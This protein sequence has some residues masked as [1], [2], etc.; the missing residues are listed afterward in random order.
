[1]I[2]DP[3][4]DI[5]RGKAV[6]I[7]P[8]DGAF[9]PNTALD[10]APVLAQLCEPD[11]LA[12]WGGR[13]IASSGNAIWDLS[14]ADTPELVENYTAQ[15]LALAVAPDGRLAV[16]LETGELLL[17]GVAQHLLPEIRAITALSFAHDGTLWLATGSS[18]HATSD[19]QSDLMRKSATGSIWQR[20]I[21]G[22]PFH[23][24]LGDLAW[25]Y[26]LCPRSGGRMAFSESWRHRVMEIDCEGALTPLIE[27][28]PGYPARLAA[29]ADGGAILSVFA[30]RNRLIEFILQE[31]YYREERIAQVPRDYWI[32]P[33]LASGKSF[34][35]P[36]QCGAIRTMGVHK[37][38]S[39][40][41]SYGMVVRLDRNMQPVSSWH[42]RANGKRHGVCAALEW[43]GEVIAASKGGDQVLSLGREG[44]A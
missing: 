36:L 20:K 38:W 4:L 19:W 26:G 16:A 44:L 22:E 37:P 28:I 18:K 3:I 27:M 32:A 5:F 35:E 30:P 40:T 13:L 9:R 12:V 14:G 10:E 7:P 39:P 1:M 43:Q 24:V 25:P 23:K 34:L 2:F 21:E 11:N 6:T 42:S 15:R 29:T 31:K 33:A 17:D 8:M 41:R